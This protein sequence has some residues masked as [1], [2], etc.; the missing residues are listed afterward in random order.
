[1]RL[2][3]AR[4]DTCDLRQPLKLHRL[5]EPSTQP[6]QRTH[7]VARQNRAD[8]AGIRSGRF[9]AAFYRRI[10]AHR[11]GMPEIGRAHV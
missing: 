2:Q 10:L 1:M 3:G 4:P 6:D 11:K 8:R 5:V 9:F 7:Q